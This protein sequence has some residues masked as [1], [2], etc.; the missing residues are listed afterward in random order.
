MPRV[1]SLFIG[2]WAVSMMLQA[3]A[4]VSS[5]GQKIAV[6]AVVPA[7]VSQVPPH[8]RWCSRIVAACSLLYENFVAGH[9]TGTDAFDGLWTERGVVLY[10]KYYRAHN[11]WHAVRCFG[12]HRKRHVI[13]HGAST[14]LVL[15]ADACGHSLVCSRLRRSGD[16]RESHACSLPLVLLG[17]NAD[18]SMPPI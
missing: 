10:C 6:M 2:S 4:G 15:A 8:P 1:V 11:G 9:A 17:A 7:E 16:H 3:L 18:Q 14:G 12:R 13:T 5:P